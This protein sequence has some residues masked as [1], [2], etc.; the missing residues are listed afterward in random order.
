MFAMYFH[1][2]NISVAFSAEICIMRE[3]FQS[4]QRVDSLRPQL[5]SDAPPPP[6]KEQSTCEY[7]FAKDVVFTHRSI[8][9]TELH[10]SR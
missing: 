8:Q 6:I 1:I 5:F 7:R 4:T 2:K 3:P 9:Q 10:A